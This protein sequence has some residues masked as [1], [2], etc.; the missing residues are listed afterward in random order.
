MTVT[1]TDVIVWLIG[2]ATGFYCGWILKSELVKLKGTKGGYI[3]PKSKASK[4][5]RAYS[6]TKDMERIMAGKEESYFEE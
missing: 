4:L 1:T 6:P 2:L 5:L 3:T